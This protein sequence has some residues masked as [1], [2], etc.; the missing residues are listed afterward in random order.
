MFSGAFIVS[1][2]NKVG[3]KSSTCITSS[4]G[5]GSRPADPTLNQHWNQYPALQKA[6]FSPSPLDSSCRI[7]SPIMPFPELRRDS[8]TWNPRVV[9][10]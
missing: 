8:A 3:E 7:R 6:A 2:Q 5:A 10:V 1:P 4:I 9:Q